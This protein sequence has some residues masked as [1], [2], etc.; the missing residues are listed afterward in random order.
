MNYKQKMQMMYGHG[1]KVENAHSQIDELTSLDDLANQ[2]D[3]ETIQLQRSGMTPFGGGTN[4]LY[5]AQ[6]EG[7]DSREILRHEPG[8]P[9]KDKQ[10][11]NLVNLISEVTKNP[12]FSDTLTSENRGDIIKELNYSGKPLRYLYNLIVGD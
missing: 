11:Q 3:P 2:I 12:A 9:T 7:G 5:G 10:I 6:T 1:G 4:Y 8:Y